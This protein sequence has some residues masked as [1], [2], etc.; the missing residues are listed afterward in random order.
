M[1][2]GL[3]DAGGI[4]NRRSTYQPQRRAPR[5]TYGEHIAAALGV[6]IGMLAITL[7]VVALEVTR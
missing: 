5:I 1:P 6:S 2:L 4:M 3:G 7:L